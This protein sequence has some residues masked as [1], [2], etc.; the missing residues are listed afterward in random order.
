MTIKLCTL[1]KTEM[2]VKQ[3]RHGSFWGCINYPK[4]NYTKNI[5][6]LNKDIPW[7]SASAIG[8]AKFCPNTVYLRKQ[9]F[10][11]NNRMKYGRKSHQLASRDT[12]CYIASYA[13]HSQHPIVFTLQDWRDQTLLRTRYGKQLVIFYYFISPILIKLF[14]RCLWFKK[15]SQYF[16]AIFVKKILRRPIC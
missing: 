4:C 8:S 12:R 10:K 5:Y 15:L 16:I 11:Q 3:G 7:V 1:C 6:Y 9:Q 14:G 2:I 13:F